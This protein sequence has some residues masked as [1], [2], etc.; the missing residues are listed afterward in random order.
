MQHRVAR[1]AG[2]RPGQR[3]FARPPHIL[4]R[5]LQKLASRIALYE[6]RAEHCFCPLGGVSRW[7]SA[8]DEARTVAH[9]TA[10]GINIV[11]TFVS[12]TFKETK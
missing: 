11:A 6:G 9:R 3:E 8:L 12:I 4:Q 2:R 7:R 1:R 5:E 10:W